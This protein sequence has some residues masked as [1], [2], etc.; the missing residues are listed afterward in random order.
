MK[1]IYFAL[2]VTFFLLSFVSANMYLEVE[3]LELYNLKDKID[4]SLKIIPETVF[5]DLLKVNLKCGNIET[6]IYKKYL[7]LENQSIIK[8][9]IPLLK[10]FIGESMG[11]CEITSTY[12]SNTQSLSE[13]FKISNLININIENYSNSFDP[14]Q[15]IIFQGSA[16]R[17]NGKSVN[18]TIEITSEFREKKIDR[19]NNGHFS[20]EIL[21]P[22][23]TKA[24]N[25]KIEFYIY[26]TN[27]NGEVI[28][29]GESKILIN[30]RQ[31]PTNVE[32]ILSKKEIIPEEGIGMELILHDQTGEKMDSSIKIVIKN[33]L[34]EIIE[35]YKKH[36]GINFNYIV[37]PKE[38]PGYWTI[39]ASTESVRNTVEFEILASPKV[40]IEIINRTV[41]FTNIGNVPYN[42]TVDILI[43]EDLVSLPIYLELEGTE[44]YNLYAP[45]GE[46]IVKAGDI[47]RTVFL[48]G[49]SIDVKKDSSKINRA[50]NPFLIWI[51]L[52]LILGFVAV[53]V[54]KR[55]YKKPFFGKK[56]EKSVVKEIKTKKVSI[57]HLI[58]PHTKADLA[59]SITGSKQ[60]AC[61]GCVYIKNFKEIQSGE[62]NVKETFAKIVE[63]IEAEKGLVYHN[64]E[65]LFYIFAPVRTKTFNNEI[66]GVKVS[67]KIKKILKEHNKKF[68]V[69]INFGVSLNYG[70]IVTKAEH[71]HYKFMSMGTL[72]TAA[73]KL[74][75]NAKE[76]IYITEKVK[77]RLGKEIKTEFKDLGSMT[78]HRIKEIAE[79]VEHSTFLKGFVDRQKKEAMKTRNKEEAKKRREIHHKK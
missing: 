68:K 69:I 66:L 29:K 38:R 5:D 44:K 8:I 62:G 73:K 22:E 48:T 31:V 6:E 75:H 79:K 63:V 64:K 11:E 47:E 46:Y 59:L 28:N 60:N 19:V 52:I 3:P 18:G 67:D 34:G 12:G 55:Y 17:E 24:G 14:G 4:I 13:K 70:T 78:A 25:K 51:F 50:Y 72:M 36:T 30:I 37:Q 61:V 21:I 53:I 1:K 58:V 20:S 9:I 10:K 71:G 39:T 33:Q 32:V 49:R 43:G 15:K 7:Y 23:G 65:S 54:F 35:K 56:K 42:N 27:Q 2:V 57:N 40:N 16:L 77:E 45:K 76:E 41:I 26:E 74:A